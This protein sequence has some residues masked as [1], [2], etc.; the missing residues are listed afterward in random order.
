MRKLY[1]L[2]IGLAVT[3]APGAAQDDWHPVSPDNTWSITDSTCQIDASWEGDIFIVINRHEDHHDLGIYDKQI[4]G[5]VAEKIISVRFGID[6]DPKPAQEY[7]AIGHMEDGQPS[8]VSNVD[9]G[10]LDWIAAGGSFQVY[11]GKKLIEDLDMTGFAQALAAAR[12]CE[13]MLPPDLGDDSG[14]VAAPADWEGTA[15]EAATDEAMTGA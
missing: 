10:L 13:A 14:M 12:A 5:L 6:G 7:P 9:D 1:F 4:K 8:Y 2:A 11:R 3:A 15:A